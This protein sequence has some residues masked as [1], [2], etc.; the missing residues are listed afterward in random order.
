MSVLAID[1][2]TDTGYALFDSNGR[3]YACGLGDPRS[4][5]KHVVRNLTRVVIERPMVYPGGR[6]QAKPEDIIKLA[7][8]AGEWAGVYR[9]WADIEFVA[10]FQWKGS[11][12]KSIHHERIKAKLSPAELEI[13]VASFAPRIGIPRIAPSKQHNIVDAVGLGLFAVGR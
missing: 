9:Q 11:V 5:E 7:L 12:P 2:G 10:P 4:N 13:V 6:Q 8:K 1:P 3:L